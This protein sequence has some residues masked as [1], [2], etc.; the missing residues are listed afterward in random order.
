MTDQVTEIT[1]TELNQIVQRECPWCK[2]NTD[3]FDAQFK[4][5]EYKCNCEFA[6]PD[7]EKPLQKRPFFTKTTFA[8]IEWEFRVGLASFKAWKKTDIDK[9]RAWALTKSNM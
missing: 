3:P 4:R 8:H 9:L 5:T 2:C 7:P 1:F 6:P